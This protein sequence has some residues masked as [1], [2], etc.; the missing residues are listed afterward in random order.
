MQV[1]LESRYLVEKE[2]RSWGSWGSL[3]SQGGTDL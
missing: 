1:D 2:H 3:R